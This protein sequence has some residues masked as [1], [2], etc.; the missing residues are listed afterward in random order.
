MIFTRSD[1]VEM[2][3]RLRYA[4]MLSG[5]GSKQRTNTYRYRSSYATFTVVRK[6]GAAPLDGAN[7]WNS[8]MAGALRQIASSSL[9]SSVGGAGARAA[10]A[11]RTGGASPARGGTRE[12]VSDCAARAMGASDASIDSASG[13][14]IPVGVC[15]A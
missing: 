13:K 4:R 6:D 10:T 5:W 3:R 12:G 14:R 11:L 9:P 7:C 15:E 1:G 8:V 2:S